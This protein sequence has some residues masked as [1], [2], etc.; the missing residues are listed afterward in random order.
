MDIE[1]GI[2]VVVEIVWRCDRTSSGSYSDSA[3]VFHSV[4]LIP[5]FWCVASLTYCP[6]FQFFTNNVY[7]RGFVPALLLSI[8]FIFCSIPHRPPFC[9]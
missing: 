8:C 3:S 2:W 7:F 5:L 1:V 4:L 6:E 9:V